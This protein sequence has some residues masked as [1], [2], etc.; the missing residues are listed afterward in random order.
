MK[1]PLFVIAGTVALGIGVVGIV[2]PVLPTT[3]FLLLAAFCYMKGSRRLYDALLR[4]RI[5]GTYVRNYLEGRG[6]SLKTKIWTLAMLW[7]VMVCTAFLITDSLVV[8]V[9]LA[10]ILAGVTMHVL[11]LK[12]AANSTTPKGS[13]T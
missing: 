13:A 12:S 5:V 3:P 8:R 6:M 9:I 10:I 1:R 11:L 4:R 7:A 2:V